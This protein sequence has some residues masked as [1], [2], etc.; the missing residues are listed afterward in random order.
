[1]KTEKLEV[2][3]KEKTR[4]RKNT[5]NEKEIEWNKRKGRIKE[6]RK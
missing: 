3:H 1:V 5:R 6:H 2:R 4:N